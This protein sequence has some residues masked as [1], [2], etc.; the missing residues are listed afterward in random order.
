M[1]GFDTMQTIVWQARCFL[2]GENSYSVVK[3][4]PIGAES[5][6]SALPLQS[7]ELALAA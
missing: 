1:T 3:L 6:S 7:V 5:H 4:T 2:T